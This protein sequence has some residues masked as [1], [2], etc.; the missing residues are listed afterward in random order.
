MT[1]SNN[2]KDFRAEVKVSSPGRINLIGEHTDYNNGF[3]MPT[4][5]DKKI[6][7]DFKKNESGENCKIYSKTFDSYYEFSLNEI[8][9]Q[10]D[11]WKNYLLGVIDEIQKLNKKLLGFDCIIESELPIGA[12]ISSSAALECGFAA[13]LNKLFKLNLS[14]QE[15]VELSQRAENNFVGSNCGIMDQ[16]ASVMSKKDHIILLDCKTLETEFIPADFKNCK[17]LLLNTNVSHSLADSEYN[18]RRAE[19]EDAVEKIRQNYPEVSSLREVNIEMLEE[20]KDELSEKTYQ[21]CL[22]VLNE[23]ERVQEA[24]EA[25]KKG[26]LK[27]FG[28][29]MYQSHRGL[30]HHYE[31]SCRELDFM[32]DFSEDKDFIY[33]SRMMGGGFG[34]CTINLI[35]ADKIEDY[36]KE[37]SEAYFRKFKIKMDMISVSPGEGT[38]IS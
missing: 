8:S 33:G 13:G 6:F 14:K 25:M 12:G 5:I 9:K 17:L 23:N 26:Q 38:Q 16:F 2:F 10:E 7:F 21:R 24:S 30:Q 34:G 3:V 18:T 22:Y 11:S 32:V 1:F 4:A 28:E 29:L 35:E 37:I 27:R 20:F 19:C 36:I 15:I 31:V